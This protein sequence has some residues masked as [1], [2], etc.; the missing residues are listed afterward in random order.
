MTRRRR[1]E[2]RK[3][4][5]VRK[6]MDY[7]MLFV[8]QEGKC[9][10]CGEPWTPINPRTGKKRR[11]LHRDHDRVRM[12]PRGLLCYRCNGGLRTYMTLE[13]VAAALK[14]LEKYEPKE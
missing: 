7:D 4:E 10:I 5:E 2:N 3:H 9:A 12:I 1:K 11:K 14:Y 13:W 6:L 8:L